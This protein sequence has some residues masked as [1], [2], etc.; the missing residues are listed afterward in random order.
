MVLL[1][2]Q[3]AVVKDQDR[4]LVIVIA[5]VVRSGKDRDHVREA[6]FVTPAVHLEAVDLHLVTTEYTH[7][8]VGTQQFLHWLLAEVIGAFTFRVLVE[9]TVL[10]Y[11]VLHRVGPHQVAEKA[12]ER[13]LL[14][15]LH[16]VDFVDHLE[17]G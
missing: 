6:A 13:N 12:I 17:L 4:T 16:L 8:L 10:G 15:A 5:A 1:E 14:E 2:L 11:F 9:V 3:V 7:E